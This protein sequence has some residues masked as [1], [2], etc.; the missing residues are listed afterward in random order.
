VRR[1]RSLLDG[2]LE[3]IYQ[4]AIRAG[5]RNPPIAV[6]YWILTA[7]CGAVGV[8]V[9]E[10]QGTVAP[11]AALAVLALFALVV[12]ELVRRFALAHGIAED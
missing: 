7:L 12:S 9:A 11:L 3:H 6:V 1:R 2:H 10:A 5:W 8:A 4:I